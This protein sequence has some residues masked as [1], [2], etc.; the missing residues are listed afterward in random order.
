[1]SAQ[2]L[3]GRLIRRQLDGTLPVLLGDVA[4]LGAHDR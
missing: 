2:A 4:L 3:F 1:M